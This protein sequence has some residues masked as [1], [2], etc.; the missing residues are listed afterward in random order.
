MASLLPIGHSVGIDVKEGFGHAETVKFSTSSERLLL[1]AGAVDEIKESLAR[2]Q[3]LLYTGNRNFPFSFVSYEAENCI[4]IWNFKR[5]G[6]F[7]TLP[8]SFAYPCSPLSVGGKKWEIEF[9][10]QMTSSFV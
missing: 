2:A 3:D 5:R 6:L 4:H 8:S 7:C 10:S 1:G 9:S